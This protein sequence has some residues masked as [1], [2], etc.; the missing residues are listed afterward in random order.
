MKNIIQLPS[1]KMKGTDG[2]QKSEAR[3]IFLSLAIITA[4]MAAV[5]MND[6]ALKTSRPVY[7]ISDNTD[8]DKMSRFIA[9]TGG[10]V[11]YKDVEW[12][13][14]LAK[15]LSQEKFGIRAPASISNSVSKID[16]LRYGALAGKYSVLSSLEGASSISK[17]EY[18]A[19][20]EVS[21]QP[22]F[23]DSEKFLN[24]YKGLLAVNFDSFG[25]GQ[26]VDSGHQEYQLLDKEQKKVGKA[27]FEL[28]SDGRV[29]S[30]SVSKN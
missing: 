29:L 16:Q 15:K 23:I 3:Q 10:A 25:P 8:P 28:D 20:S 17:V 21:D 7:V 24:D 13:H 5:M 11:S 6:S 14:Q 9:S 18:V 12:E 4:V 27:S 2:L 30:I 1:R 22:L 26:K 19:S